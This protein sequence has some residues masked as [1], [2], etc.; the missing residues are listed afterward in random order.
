M[1]EAEWLACEDLQRLIKSRRHSSYDRKLRLFACACV[2]NV[3]DHLSDGPWLAAVQ[4][5]ESFADDPSCKAELDEMYHS[6][7]RVW[8]EA[9]HDWAAIISTGLTVLTPEAG[10][11]ALHASSH[12]CKVGVPKGRAS[13]KAAMAAIRQHNL[14]LF[15]CVF[16]NPFRQVACLPEWRTGTALAIA[17]QMY[18]S[19]DF[20]AMPILADALQDAGCDND[21]ILN[22]CRDPQATH[23]RGCWVVDLVLGKA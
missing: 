7:T 19:R 18:E 9:G 11:A 10:W 23:V 4:V 14:T 17:Q 22:H 1:T 8:G 6:S 16:G 12:S 15:R 5:A 20:S 13:R 2:R 3:K 21:D